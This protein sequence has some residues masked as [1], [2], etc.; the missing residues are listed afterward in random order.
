MR[1]LEQEILSL[2]SKC[3]Q[4]FF[5]MKVILFCGLEQ[6]SVCHFLQNLQSSISCRVESRNLLMKTSSI[7][8][9]T[10]FSQLE[11]CFQKW[12][13]R[14]NVQL[15]LIY[16]LRHWH[17]THPFSSSKLPFGQRS[18]Q[19]DNCGQWGGC[20]SAPKFNQNIN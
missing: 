10:T 5:I 6:I 8:H 1:V 2:T 14:K 16:L 12:W 19:L 9:S 13:I 18:V 4:S 7:T 11:K 15:K 3:L 20:T 17:E